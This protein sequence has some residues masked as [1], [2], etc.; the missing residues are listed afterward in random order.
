M[1]LALRT[2]CA[3]TIRRPG[4]INS[5]IIEKERP[6]KPGRGN[7]M[8]GLKK[9]TQTIFVPPEWAPH[10]AI[11]T[12]WPSHADLWG[13]PLHAARREV[14]AM[15]LALSKGDSVK[16]LAMGEEA[17]QSAHEAL[18]ISA[19]IIS[20]KFGDIWLRDTGPIFARGDKGLC[21]LRFKTN[22]WGGKYILEFDDEVGDAIAQ[23]AGASP[24]PQNFILEGGAIEQDG[25]GTILTTRQCVLNPN[26]NPGWDEETAEAALKEAFG[27]EKI[28]WLDEGLLND[29]TD[30]HIDNI[31]RFVAPGH[32]VCQKPAGG[33]DPNEKILNSIAKA[34][35]GMKDAKGRELKVSQ[36]PSPGFV[37][38]ENGDPVPASHMNF[39]IGNKTVVVPTYGT[40][41]AAQAV[42][43]LK[44]VFPGRE[45]IG[46]P[47]K[48][49]LTGGGS[50]HC[51]TQQEPEL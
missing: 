24:L 34:L 31:A 18:G 30:G 7:L 35:R 10:A 13:D 32:V 46:L 42:E 26:R 51:I 50:F 29:H 19:K 15:V 47:S 33:N 27:A 43:D 17:L 4:N 39:I 5:S 6:G 14:A 12:A 28:L 16:V 38:D 25:E 20:A 44:A 41:S 37:A 23:G 1:V 45:V 36:I 21:A 49:L 40:L 11:W 2:V 9:K 3:F 22:G 48:A 8:L